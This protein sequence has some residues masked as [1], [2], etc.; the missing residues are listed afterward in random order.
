MMRVLLDTHTFLWAS[1]NKPKLS[2]TALALIED[3]D[4]ELLLSVVSVWEMSIKFSNGKLV[5]PES[6]SAF[7]SAQMQDI[8]FEI[9]PLV[10]RHLAPIA[11]LPF[12]HRDPFDRLLVAQCL[13][14]DL[15]LISA[16]VLFDAY[17]ITRL[18]EFPAYA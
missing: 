3:A 16:D 4:N 12:H 7:V 15:P 8:G 18:W 1:S 10:L 13:I 2:P 5:L 9:L 11:T 17:G 14:E 6:P